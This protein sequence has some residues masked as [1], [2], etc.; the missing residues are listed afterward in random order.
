MFLGYSFALFSGRSGFW[1]RREQ[2]SPCVHPGARSSCLYV[3]SVCLSRLSLY[4]RSHNWANLVRGFAVIVS[5]LVSLYIPYTS[6]CFFSF[7]CVCVCVCREAHPCFGRFALPSG[8]TGG[9]LGQQVFERSYN[10]H[11]PDGSGVR[12]F[13]IHVGRAGH[14]GGSKACTA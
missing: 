1:G 2:K 14:P 12:T 3:V 7:S 4:V 9:R 10:T 8:K 5:I 11:A 13:S 6:T